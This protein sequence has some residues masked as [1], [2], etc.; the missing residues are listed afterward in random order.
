MST[1]STNSLERDLTHISSA[2]KETRWRDISWNPDIWDGRVKA[3][4]AGRPMFIWAM[5]GDPLGA[6]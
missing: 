1:A 2:S 4:E 6:V 3:A 5:N